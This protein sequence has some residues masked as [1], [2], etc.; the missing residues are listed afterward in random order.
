M[1]SRILK[2]TVFCFIICNLFS[3]ISFGAVTKHNYSHVAPKN[4]ELLPETQTYSKDTKLVLQRGTIISSCTLIISNVGGGDIG[5]EAETRCHRD[6]DWGLITIY[7]DQWI[8]EDQRWE[9]K[10][11]YEFEFEPENGKLHAMSVAFD[12]TNQPSG[13]YYRLWAYHEADRD[14]KWEVMRTET[15]GVMITS[16]P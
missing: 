12:E 4:T 7:L 3:F 16:D 10:E 8:E 11:T 5:I 9:T 14:G 6:V 1:K 15:N 2:V 13:Y